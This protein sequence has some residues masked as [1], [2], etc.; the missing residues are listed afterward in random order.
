MCWLIFTPI[1]IWEWRIIGSLM[2]Q[3][4]PR[5]SSV[6]KWQ[7]S[8]CV[9]CFNWIRKWCEPT[10]MTPCFNFKGQNF[11]LS[12]LITVPE[13]RSCWYKFFPMQWQI[14]CNGRRFVNTG[15]FRYYPDLKEQ[16]RKGFERMKGRNESIC[17]WKIV[18]RID[19]VI[20][21]FSWA[22]ESMAELP[23]KDMA[24]ARCYKL[25][26]KLYDEVW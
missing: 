15:D 4:V 23:E 22:H 7:G 10:P 17:I 3:M 9:Q 11:S 16:I 1:I 2:G 24:A 13:A 21:D 12:M 8:Y 19:M 26:E 6:Q 18:E 14:Q 5:L 20:V 25:V